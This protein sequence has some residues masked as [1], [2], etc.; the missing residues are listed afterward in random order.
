MAQWINKS[1]IIIHHDID[2]SIVEGN[3]NKLSRD[4][5]DGAAPSGECYSILKPQPKRIQRIGGFIAVF[6]DSSR[7]EFFNF[8]A[9][10]SFIF[11]RTFKF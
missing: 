4:K 6:E 8:F 2:D 10:K 1:S 7:R 9:S 11:L 3:R 5:D